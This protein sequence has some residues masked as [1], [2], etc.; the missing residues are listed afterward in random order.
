MQKD[1]VQKFFQ[2]KVYSETVRNSLQTEIEILQRENKSKDLAIRDLEIQVRD[3]ETKKDSLDSTVYRQSIR[4]D[5]LS[6]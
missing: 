4:I 3:L 6:E 1:N 5:T 2:E